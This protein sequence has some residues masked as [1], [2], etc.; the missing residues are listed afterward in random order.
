MKQ[1]QDLTEQGF[2]SVWTEWH[3]VGSQNSMMAAVALT[4]VIIVEQPSAVVV[5]LNAVLI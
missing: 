5:S 4:G 3:A 1:R 2:R